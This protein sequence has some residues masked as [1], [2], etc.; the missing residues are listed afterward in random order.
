MAAGEAQTGV[1]ALG[2]TDERD[3]FQLQVIDDGFDIPG[4]RG[5]V[6]A[7]FGVGVRAAV[8]STVQGRVRNPAATSATRS[9]S[10]VNS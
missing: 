1:P 5:V 3:S 2:V 8:T 10:V 7:K 6:V 9:L 4:N